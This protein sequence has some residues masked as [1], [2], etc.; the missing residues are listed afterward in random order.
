MA[1]RVLLA[2][3]EALVALALADCLE[4]DGHLVVV[5][6]DGAA[7]LAMSRGLGR[8]DLLVTDLR[9]PRLGGED[10]IRALWAERPGLPVL[11][12]TG[13][14]PPGGAEALRRD[15]GDRGPLAL[16]HKPLDYASLAGALRRL[17]E[18]AFA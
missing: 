10:L 13:S 6:G 3:D 15:A 1:L 12:V 4:A 14:A 9:M 5:A 7:A 17:A 2:E 16:L 18:P 11:V 8:L